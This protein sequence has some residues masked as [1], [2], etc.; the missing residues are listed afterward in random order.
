MENHYY[1]S[2][3]NLTSLVLEEKPLG[4]GGQACVYRIVFPG[5]LGDC[6]AK[7]YHKECSVEQVERLQYM[8]HHPPKVL[9]TSAFCICWPKGLVYDKNKMVVGF[10]MPTAFPNSRD[11]YILSYYAKGKTIAERFKKN[12]DWFGKYERNT[13]EGMMNRLKMIANISQAFYQIHKSGNYVV[14]DIKPMNILATSTG[15]ISVVDT[16]SFQIAE[17][18]RILFSAAAATPEYCAPEF[19]EQFIQ[20]R[21]FTVSNDL[22]SLSV[23]YYQIIMGVHPFTGVRLLPPYNTEEY[24]ELK[25]VIHRSLFVY[26]CNKRYIEKLNPNPHAFFERMPRTLQMM[27]IRAFDAPNYRPAMEEWCKELFKI[28]TQ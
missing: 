27:F 15:R 4:K 22:F 23:I 25:P 26:G 5:F 19:D 6:C 8:I 13:S 28:I 1:I 16:D 10:Y 2:D 20:N 9:K 21:P 11:L 14:L 3:T 18:D 7:I 24:S 12:T 17:A